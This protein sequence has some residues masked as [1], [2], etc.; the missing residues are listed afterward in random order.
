MEEPNRQISKEKAVRM[1]IERGMALMRDDLKM[2]GMTIEGEKKFI[3]ESKDYDSLWADA[4]E[5]LEKIR[6]ENRAEEYLNNWKRERADFLNYKKDEA[7]RVEEFVKYA[8]EDII[9]EVLELVDD[10]EIAAREVPGVGLEHVIKKFHDLFKKYGI[11]K[12]EVKDNFDPLFHEAVET[13]PEGKK[14][15]EIRAGYKIRDKII[16]PARV[17]ITK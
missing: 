4:I 7:K 6:P 3:S 9:L 2:Y 1:G 16:R 10:L 8:N 17:K 14:L 15:K 11:E 13:E 5:A 12:I